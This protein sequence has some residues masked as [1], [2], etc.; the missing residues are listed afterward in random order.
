MGG[1]A[2]IGLGNMGAPMAANLL[3]GGYETTVFDLVPEALAAAEEAGARAAGSAAEAV[4][5]AEVVISMLPAG[6]HV[7]ELY[8]G[9]GQ[10]MASVRPGTLLV[11][12]ST[13]AADA[14]RQVAAA[15]RERSLRF[16][17]A[18]V[19]GGVGGARAGTL[20]F[21]CGGEAADVEEARPVL[22]AMGKNVFHAGPSGAGQVGKMCNNM[23]LA[24]QMIGTA[25]ALNLA[26][27]HGLDPAAVSDIMKA[28]SGSNWAL[29]VYNP[30]P[31]VMDGVPASNG[32]QGGFLVDLM[33]KDL[34]LAMD[35]AGSSHTATPL[36]AAARALYTAHS[37]H[38]NGGYDFSSILQFLR[39]GK[40]GE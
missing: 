25:E 8:L 13:I 3:R 34:G 28:S 23:L 38:G 20:T 37:A 10:V 29:Q 6:E 31:G 36:G 18:P 17:D 5:D 16:L 7:H 32:Y 22:A 9:S 26:D 1:V 35:M 15:A 39:G 14:A 27:A 12:C 40:L 33:V 30:Y 19:S 21:I 24:I 4:A 11:D 2:F